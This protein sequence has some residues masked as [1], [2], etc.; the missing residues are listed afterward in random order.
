[1]TVT[2]TPDPVEE[3]R[4]DAAARIGI[5]RFDRDG[6]EDMEFIRGGQVFF[7]TKTERKKNQRKVA[8]PE[9]DPFTNGTCRLLGGLPEDD[10]EYES[11]KSQPAS[12][13]DQEIED[14]LDGGM[15]DFEARVVQ[16]TSETALRRILLAAEE[17]GAAA[18]RLNLLRDRLNGLER[19]SPVKGDMVTDG[20]PELERTAPR[21]TPGEDDGQ[22]G[23]RRYE[24]DND[25]AMS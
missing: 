22:P 9:Y 19:R 10:D 21:M 13:T 6:H 3:W 1:M 5:I 14:L 12:M 8:L 16:L 15:P 24:I 7:I 23:P 11:L 2:E 18:R 17:Q 4:N 25:L 20:D